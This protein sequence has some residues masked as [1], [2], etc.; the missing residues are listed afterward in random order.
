MNKYY[1]LLRKSPAIDFG[2]AIA[3]NGGQDF[4]GNPIADGAT[5]RGS[6]ELLWGDLTFDQRVN[7]EDM[8]ELGS[9]WQTVYDMDTLLEVANN[10]LHGTSP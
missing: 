1:R 7:L 6:H 4:W 2:A 5:D 9:K 10:W 8:A 3:S